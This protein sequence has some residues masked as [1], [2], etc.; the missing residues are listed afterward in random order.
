MVGLQAQR[1]AQLAA[2]GGLPVSAAPGLS[3]LQHVAPSP[4]DAFMQQ[5]IPV[6]PQV[7]PQA[8]P[9]V[10]HGPAA[11]GRHAQL[12]RVAKGINNLTLLA[13]ISLMLGAGAFI[14]DPEQRSDILN[15]LDAL[16]M[17]SGAP[18]LGDKARAGAYT[19]KHS[20]D[21]GAALR[22]V[23]ADVGTETAL[24][25]IPVLSTIIHSILK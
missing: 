14:E 11:A 8:P 15:V 5:G 4:Y 23:G 25:A 12:L 19:L 1:A 3:I 17:A 7:Q 9:P 10:V 2:A 24:Q 22:S 20:P 18:L 21:T 6:M 16:Q 13:R